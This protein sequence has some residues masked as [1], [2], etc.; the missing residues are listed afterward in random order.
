M[1]NVFPLTPAF[2]R[3]YT[4]FKA[5]KQDFLDGKDFTTVSGQMCSVR[6]FAKGKLISF[7]YAHKT[8]AG[9]FVL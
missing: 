7:R 1:F 6:D 3:D 8:K 2:G 4:S 9:S 5:L